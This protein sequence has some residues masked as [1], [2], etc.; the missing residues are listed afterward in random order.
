MWFSSS[1]PCSFTSFVFLQTHDLLSLTFSH[2]LS[3]I[4]SRSLSL[5]LSLTH[6]HTLSGTNELMTVYSS[7]LAID[8]PEYGSLLGMLLQA[9]LNDQRSLDGK[10]YAIGQQQRAL[11][12]QVRSRLLLRSRCSVCVSIPAY[13]AVAQSLTSFV[14]F[15]FD[16]HSTCDD[17]CVCVC[18]CVFCRM[19]RFFETSS[20][21]PSQRVCL[22]TRQR[23]AK[24]HATMPKIRMPSS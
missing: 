22:T 13:H 14:A 6:A 23:P 4:L 3:F 2:F 5:S 1:L 16:S 10:K 15:V 24:H 11:T 9:V 7:L 17:M 19:T 20:A 18:V 8:Y 12:P 21:R